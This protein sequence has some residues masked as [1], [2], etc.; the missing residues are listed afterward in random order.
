ML[1]DVVVSSEDH[2]LPQYADVDSVEVVPYP[3]E[4]LVEVV[5]DVSIVHDFG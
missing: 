5:H 2:I 3:L 1:S 4:D